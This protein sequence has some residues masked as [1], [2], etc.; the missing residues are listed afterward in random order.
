[1]VHLIFVTKY[2]KQLLVK[3]DDEIKTISDKKT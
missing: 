3:Y 1:M 2:R